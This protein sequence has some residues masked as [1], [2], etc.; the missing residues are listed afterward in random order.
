MSIPVGE[1]V[2]LSS[3]GTSKY[4]D[5]QNNPWDG[6]GVVIR[7]RFYIVEWE[8]GVT[9]S[10][11]EADLEPCIAIAGN[12]YDEGELESCIDP[13]LTGTFLP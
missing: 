6:I 11:D 3:H 1:T 2:R 4:D 10:Y 7:E 8:P 5:T 13:G 12:S 9:N